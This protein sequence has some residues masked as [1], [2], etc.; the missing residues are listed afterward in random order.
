MMNTPPEADNVGER[1]EQYAKVS[2]EQLARQCL[3]V[4]KPRPGEAGDLWTPTFGPV[5]VPPGWEFLPRGD[6]FITRQVKKGPHWTLMGRFN[7]GGRYTPVLGVYAPA[8]AIATARASAKQTEE[9]RAPAREKSRARRDKAEEQ[10]RAE[11]EQACLRFLGFA[12]EHEELARSIARHAT[13][14]ACEKHSGRVG[15]TS[16][17][18]LDTKAELAVRA[19]IRHLHTNYEEHLSEHLTEEDYYEVKGDAQ[20]DVDRFLQQHSA[21]KD[22]V[23]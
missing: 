4:Y 19:G 23:H 1:S 14:R 8:E 17:L 3:T 9:K 5:E 10:Y 22:G 6:A 20:A 21:R 18:S 2:H 11:F 16:R 15:R 7:K 13:E 12:P